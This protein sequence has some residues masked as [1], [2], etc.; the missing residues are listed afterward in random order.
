MAKRNMTAIPQLHSFNPEADN[1]GLPF[2]RLVKK[3]EVRSQRS[4]VQPM[5]NHSMLFGIQRTG[6][7]TGTDEDVILGEH[8]YSPLIEGWMPKADGVCV[9]P[10]FA[11]ESSIKHQASSSYFFTA[12]HAE[13][14]NTIVKK[15]NSD[16]I[17][18]D[19][20]REKKY[21]LSNPV[22]LVSRESRLAINNLQC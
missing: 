14:E 15:K 6:R 9:T 1:I 20:I 5:I 22:N 18:E 10:A 8:P 16:R 19:K 17:E 2:L 7:E 11:L 4:E 3:S 21:N 12:A 13:K